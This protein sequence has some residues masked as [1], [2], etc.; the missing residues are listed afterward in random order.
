MEDWLDFDYRQM[1]EVQNP[2]YAQMPMMQWQQ[3]IMP[4]QQM[5]TPTTSPQATTMPGT[6]GMA[7][8]QTPVVEGGPDFEM[9]PG[10]PVQ[11]NRNYIQG[12]LR[13]QLGKAMRV[14]F[15]I[16]TNILTDRVGT[17]VEVGI[18]HIALVPFNSNDLQIADIYSI[19][20]VEVFGG[21]AQYPQQIISTA[22]PTR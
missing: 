21:A 5:P 17:L 9:E 10:A 20:F 3:P 8:A 13:T 7:G 2:M 12:F 6:T 22:T 1:P 15:L 18:D 16:G 4:Y 14:E 11:Q 19:K